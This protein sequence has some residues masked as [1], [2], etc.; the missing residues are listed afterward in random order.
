MIS[1]PRHLIFKH[2]S[3]KATQLRV[4]AYVRHLGI[5]TA[6]YWTDSDDEVATTLNISRKTLVRSYKW[7]EVQGYLECVGLWRKSR[8]RRYKL[9][10]LIRH[11]DGFLKKSKRLTFSRDDIKDNDSFLLVLIASDVAGKIKAAEYE[12]RKPSNLRTKEA[13]ACRRDKKGTVTKVRLPFAYFCNRYSFG[14]R[15]FKRLQKLGNDLLLFLSHSEKVL[16]QG[17][18]PWALPFIDRKTENGY[19][20]M[21]KDGLVYERFTTSYSKYSFS[22]NGGSGVSS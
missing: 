3:R 22:H 6:G 7:L 4:L 21:N 20:F 12:E 19:L 11:N 16:V 18:S 9:S 10:S 15:R 17:L 14:N 2:G 5:G 1:L 13:L 8:R